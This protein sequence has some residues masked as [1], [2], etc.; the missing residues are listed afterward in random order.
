[1]RSFVGGVAVFAWSEST[2]MA[3]FGA[4][5][6][7][8]AVTASKTPFPDAPEA[9]YT[10]SAPPSSSPRA[11]SV[12]FA[13]SLKPVKSPAGVRYLLSI[14]MFGATAFAPAA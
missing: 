8:A 10:M 12:A 6:V 14:W 4:S 5:A 13:G 2:P 3:H 7:L 9:W 11:T 1:M